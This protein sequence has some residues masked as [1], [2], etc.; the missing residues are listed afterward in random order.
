MHEAHNAQRPPTDAAAATST[1]W[2][3]VTSYG[4]DLTGTS[5]CVDAFNEAVTAVAKA[6]GG[7]VYIPAGT[8]QIASTVTLH[9]RRS[10]APAGDAYPKAAR[11]TPVVDR[12]RGAASEH[13]TSPAVS[14]AGCAAAAG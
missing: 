5:D 7:V 10:G 3:N 11:R 6:G 8:Y 12:P 9:P 2:V 4:A 14:R 1:G 13:T